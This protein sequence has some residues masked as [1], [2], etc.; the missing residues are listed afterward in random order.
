MDTVL[1]KIDNFIDSDTF[2]VIAFF[3]CIGLSTYA[4]TANSV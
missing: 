1:R 3:I 2:L 4:L